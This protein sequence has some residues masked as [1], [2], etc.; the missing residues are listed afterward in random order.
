M[1]F[2]VVWCVC[3]CVYLYVCVCMCMRGVHPSE[4]LVFRILFQVFSLI[5]IL[6]LE[7]ECF[8]GKEGALLKVKTQDRNENNVS[9]HSLTILA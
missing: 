9:F 2:G 4:Y 8:N 3:V 7:L 5:C 1:E 6:Q